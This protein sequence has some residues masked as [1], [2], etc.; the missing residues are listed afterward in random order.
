MGK[1]AS[2]PCKER[3]EEIESCVWGLGIDFIRSFCP[4]FLLPEIIE[5]PLDL[6][7]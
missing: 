3:R 2:L 1:E 5:R 4:Y 6:N 7:E